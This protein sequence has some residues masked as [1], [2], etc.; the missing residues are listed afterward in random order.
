MS[1]SHHLVYFGKRKS[2]AHHLIGRPRKPHPKIK[3]HILVLALQH[4]PIQK[5]LSL[6][7]PFHTVVQVRQNLPL[8]TTNKA[9]RDYTDD[10]DDEDKWDGDSWYGDW[11]CR[12]SNVCS[13]SYR[14]R[15][16]TF[17]PDKSWLRVCKKISFNKVCISE[18]C[19]EMCISIL[20]ILFVGPTNQP[21]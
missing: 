9:D 3:H 1:V 2:H 11:D 18:K 4:R 10:S 17:T 6:C 15:N 21:V 19:T 14:L 5:V 13:F 20:L 12:C 16:F 8:S 7:C